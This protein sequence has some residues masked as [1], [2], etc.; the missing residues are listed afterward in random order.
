MKY[1]LLI[2]FALVACDSGEEK[3]YQRLKA[4]QD[5][6]ESCEALANCLGGTGQLG[7]SE[8]ETEWDCVIF[9]NKNPHVFR[10]VRESRLHA[11]LWACQTKGEINETCKFP[12]ESKPKASPSPSKNE[13]NR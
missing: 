6:K 11:A 3:A 1:L 2:V 5:R 4:E 12:R 7:M 8:G 13:Y 10:G 9:R